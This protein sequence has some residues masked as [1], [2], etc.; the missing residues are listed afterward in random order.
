MKNNRYFRSHI[1]VLVSGL[2]QIKLLNELNK[3]GI[4]IKNLQKIDF[5]HLKL[6]LRA[7]DRVKSFA[8]LEKMCYT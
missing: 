4:L 2:N 1:T 3:Q 6:T 7:K 5:S 8:I